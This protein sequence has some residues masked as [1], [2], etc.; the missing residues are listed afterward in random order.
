[1]GEW[2]LIVMVWNAGMTATFDNRQACDFALEG[3]KQTYGKEHVKGFCT[4]KWI[5]ETKR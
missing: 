1:M 3:A 5:E 4:P 2:I